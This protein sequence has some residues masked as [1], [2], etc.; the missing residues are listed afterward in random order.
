V[1]TGALQDGELTELVLPLADPARLGGRLVD[2]AHNAVAGVTLAVWHG[3]GIQRPLALDP[4]GDV[5]SA[6]S[7]A[8][9]TFELDGLPP[10]EL[11]LRISDPRWRLLGDRVGELAP[12]EQ[13]AGLE[14]VL[15]RAA[16]LRGVVV[17]EFAAPVAGAHVSAG[18]RDGLGGLMVATT[19]AQGRYAF[20]AALPGE[21]VLG[22]SCDGRAACSA[23]VVALGEGERRRANLVLG[24]GSALRVDVQDSQAPLSVRVTD[25][26]GFLRAEQ[27]VWQ[28][29]LELTLPPGIY[30]VAL[31]ARDGTCSERRLVL[32]GRERRTCTLGL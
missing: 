8:D 31:E 11:S 27:R 18:R 28:G 1:A 9:G 32:T 20:D 30:R 3:A 24:R 14:L 25:A 12:G 7:G 4:W 26:V 19:D 2:G 13:R 6:T 16:S 21:Y 15:L 23:G 17:D 10:G 29:E 5:L 22:A